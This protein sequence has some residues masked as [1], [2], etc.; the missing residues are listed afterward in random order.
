MLLDRYKMWLVVL[1]ALLV[2]GSANA[3][4]AQDWTPFGPSNIRYDLD[5]FAP[6]DLSAYANW[7]RPNEGMFF[8]YDRLYWAIS[9]PRRQAIGEPGTTEGFFNGPA[10]FNPDLQPVGSSILTPYSSSADN[11]F[12]HA[13]QTW[14]NRFE[15]GFVEDDKG[16]LVSIMNLQNQTQSYVFNSGTNAAG[17]QNPAGLTMVFRDPQHLLLGFVDTNNDTYD[18]D[19]NVGNPLVI[20]TPNVFGRPKNTSGPTPNANLAPDGTIIPTTYAGFTDFGDEVPLVPLFNTITAVN[21]TSMVGTE[22]T[23]TWQYPTTQYGVWNL[24]FGVRWLLLRDVFGVTAVN[25]ASTTALADGSGPLVP[26][27]LPGTSFWD[28]T[29][30]NN[31]FG[32]QIGFRY[33]H[34][35]A[36]FSILTEF[37]F[38]AAVNFQSTHLNGELA[39]G[40][41]LAT[42]NPTNVP[43]LLYGTAFNSW[44]YDETFSPVGELRVGVSYQLTKA[45]AVQ[46]GYN[47]ILGGGISRASRRIDYVLPALQINNTNKN[48]AFF[49][50]GINLGVS[51][52]R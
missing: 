45:V 46:A 38:M 5:L 44:K 4:R 6:P 9:G 13:D 3:A 52:N 8:Q 35:V 21:Q 17:V 30:D 43:L 25:D 11:G 47:A 34:D 39:S 12:I 29:V 51:F 26:E 36:R 10:Q 50:D 31:M 2:G 18:D 20:G 40:L 19:L 48:D 49:T 27:A 33:S 24:L 23:R 7:P 37:R 42:A 41:P 22:I 15:L 16:W 1:T 32:P 28:S 14:G